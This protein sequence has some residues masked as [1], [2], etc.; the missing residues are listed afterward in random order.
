MLVWRRLFLLKSGIL[1][2][3]QGRNWITSIL[4]IFSNTNVNCTWSNHWL[5][6][7]A[8]T[9]LP[10]TPRT[11]LVGKW[12]CLSL[13]ILDYATFSPR[14]QLKMRH[15]SCWDGPYITHNPMRDFPL[16]L[17]NVVPGSLKSFI[18]LDHQ[19][20]ICLH[21]TKATALLHSRELVS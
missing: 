18:K 2:I 15:T 3:S 11:K 4:R 20:D 6:H 9:S 8:R 5:H 10:T 12:L 1:S 19:I 17:K 21:L 14:M 7:N 16:L 13:E